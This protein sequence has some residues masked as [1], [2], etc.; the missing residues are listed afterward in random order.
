MTISDEEAL[1]IAVTLGGGM[2]VDPSIE[3]PYVASGL[4]GLEGNIAAPIGQAMIDYKVGPRTLGLAGTVL[5]GYGVAAGLATGNVPLVALSLDQMYAN[6]NLAVNGE[7]SPTFLNQGLQAGLG[8]QPSE[9][10]VAEMYITAG[11]AAGPSAINAGRTFVN[12]MGNAASETIGSIMTPYTAAGRSMTSDSGGLGLTYRPTSGVV[13]QSQ[14]GVTTTILGSY[15]NDMRY[16]IGELGNVK[17]TEFGPRVGGFNVLNVPDN[18]YS[19]KTFWGD[20]N[21]PWLNNAIDRRDNFLLATTPGFDVPD[22]KSGI[23]VLMRPNAI[24]GKMEL[25]GF[26][27]EYL[28]MRQNGYV[29]QNGV[30]VRKW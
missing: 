5:S 20:Y 7:S 6:A 16:V 14:E 13:L 19:P 10:A 12:G 15:N 2:G 11:V 3:N 21:R 29:Y 22:A 1:S 23:S 9:A 24:T 17:S 27:R 25:S 28:M 8:L 30:M 18:L 4:Y 26:G